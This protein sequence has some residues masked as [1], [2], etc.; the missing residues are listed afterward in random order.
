MNK[1]IVR[2][3]FLLVELILFTVAFNLVTMTLTKF[4]RSR[5]RPRVEF[6]HSYLELPGSSS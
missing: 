4:I 3:V 2:A 5:H 1:T 6:L